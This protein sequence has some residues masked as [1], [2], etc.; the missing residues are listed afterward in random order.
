MNE[1][2][3]KL[4]ELL[5]ENSHHKYRKET[6]GIS[7]LNGNNIYKPF[8]IRKAIAFKE[9]LTK[10]P[11]FIQDGELIVGGKTLYKLPEYITKE[12]INNGI[13][14]FE[15][16]L[17]KKYDEYD[18]Y[19]IVKIKNIY[20]FGHYNIG[21]DERGY[22][23]PDSC[24]PNYSK[25]VKLGLPGIIEKVKE[26]LALSEDIGTVDYLNAVL[27]CYEGLKI[28]I[29]RYLKLVLEKMENC[30]ESRL[31][32]LKKIKEVLENIKK[33]R[34]SNF[35]ETLQLVYFIQFCCWTENSYL[36][37]IG[38]FDQFMYEFY[39]K[40]VLDNKIFSREDIK[41]LIE[42]FNIKLNYEIDRTHG[43]EGKIDSNTGQTIVLAGIDPITKDNAVNELTYLCLE[44]C[45]ELKLT[46]PKIHI[47]F[48]EKSSEMLWDKAIELLSVGMGF[49][50]F[51][52][53]E[54]TIKA[55]RKVGK[56]YY[57]EE[58][59]DDYGIAGCWEPIIPGRSSFKQ[60]G[61][62]SLLQALEFVLNKGYS[63]RDIK[64]ENKWGLYV[65]DL[66]DFKTFGD[67]MT[68]Y[69]KE[70]RFII[71]MNA[72]YILSTK[73]TH[74]PF[75]SSLI[76]DCI[77]K[78][79]D[80][81]EGGARYNEVDMSCSSLANAADSLYI[82]KKIVFDEK[83]LSLGEFVNILK[84]NYVGQE[85]LRQEIL[86]KYDHFGNDIDEVDLIAKEIA[87]FA[88]DEFTRYTNGLNGPFRQRI[89]GGGID[90]YDSKELGAS[91]DGRKIGDFLALNGSPQSGVSNNGPTAIVKSFTKLDLTKFAGMS[92]LNI[93]FT[94]IL[95]KD[96][97]GKDGLRN[98]IK[99]YFKMGGQQLH[100]N[101]IDSNILKEAQKEPEKYKDLIVRV[102]GFS[103]YFVNLPKDLQDHVIHRTEL[104]LK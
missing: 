91:A 35:W 34:P 99:T 63:F 47:R 18:D 14:Y 26:K 65:G 84:D 64:R 58:D 61:N 71:M 4:R 55:L 104:C 74:Q 83:R 62:F 12:E 96:K 39:K 51:D 28:L 22:G 88:A 57:R 78:G 76:D 8:V 40:D 81:N 24:P 20:N 6:L 7:I 31:K 69:K 1:R 56:G 30:R 103:A 11:I 25:V 54:A 82:I 13:K 45:G 73:W 2:I 38:R 43:K 19:N 87:E 37:P 97:E 33:N 46:D 94:P 98:L 102:W 86:N 10:L 48:N 17:T 29:D 27:I 21:Q 41:E 9:A 72:F 77:E 15:D 53:E 95:V 49:P 70:L 66:E 85:D 75:L 42:C 59:I 93:K 90:I 89:A 23:I 50:G 36:V 3:K 80:I 92:V 44:I 5:K 16:E 68:V 67:L 79:L 60:S 52:N 100:I 101:I 32:E